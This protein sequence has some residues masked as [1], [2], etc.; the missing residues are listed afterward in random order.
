VPDK[1]F[2]NLKLTVSVPVADALERSAARRGVK[3]A[4]RASEIL[5]EKLLGEDCTARKLMERLERSHR[6]C[7]R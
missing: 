7:E 6:K 3:L 1:R 5:E 2:I 4:T